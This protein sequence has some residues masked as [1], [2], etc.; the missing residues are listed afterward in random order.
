[1][2]V[3]L[4]ITAPCLCFKIYF[5]R[6]RYIKQKDSLPWS[7]WLMH[8]PVGIVC[9][10]MCSKC[11]SGDGGISY[12]ANMAQR[13]DASTVNTQ[14]IPHYF[15]SSAFEARMYLLLHGEFMFASPRCSILQALSQIRWVKGEVTYVMRIC[16]WKLCTNFLIEGNFCFETKFLLMCTECT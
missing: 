3:T 14:E 13:R 10:T 2:R 11:S 5:L 15:S 12:S 4:W 16:N 9:H 6:I 1:M 7:R 8:K